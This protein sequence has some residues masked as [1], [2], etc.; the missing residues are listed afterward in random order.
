MNNIARWLPWALVVVAGCYVL[1]KARPPKDQ[2]AFLL[3]QAGQTPV[4]E[5]GR[6]KPLDTYARVALMVISDRQEL[7]RPDGAKLTA[8]EW[9][10][11]VMSGSPAADDHPIFR[12]EHEDVLQLAGLTPRSGL[13]YALADF[14]EAIPKIAEQ[15]QKALETPSAKRTI[16]QRKVLELGNHLRLYMTIARHDAPFLVPPDTGNDVHAWRQLSQ[17]DEQALD[18]ARG[19]VRMHAARDGV[20]LSHLSDDDYRDMLIPL[21]NAARARIS[22][23]AAMWSDML[24]AYGRGE[25]ATYNKLVGEYNAQIFQQAPELAGPTKFE[26]FFNSFAPFFWAQWL[27]VP[28]FVLVCL[29]WLAW[30]TPLLR[31]AMGLL[32]LILVVHTFGLIARMI[33]MDRPMVFVTNLYSSAVFIGWGAVLLTLLLE[34]IYRNGIGAALG[35]L[36]GFLTLHVAHHLALTSDGDTI[37]QMRA[38]LDTNFWLATHVTTVTMGYMATFVAG[39]ISI[40][41]IL[42]GLFTPALTKPAML[43]VSQKIYGVLCFALLLSFTGTVLGGIWA[44]QS[45]GR[46]WGWDPKENGALLIVIWNAVIL[47]ARWGGM[48]KARGTA[49]MAVFGNIVTCWSWFGVNELGVGLHS[50]GFTEGT[51]F[52]LA[53]FCLS[54]LAIIGLGLIPM[55]WWFSTRAP[56]ERASKRPPESLLPAGA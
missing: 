28:V 42:G 54:Q 4:L 1:S 50:Y 5:K 33:I 15:D 38:V 46:F 35:A 20:D 31:A 29:A 55:K 39:F 32:A 44:D 6:I 11:D 51:R 10:M 3:T 19:A 21:V 13:R 53:M 49:V 12:I 24:S 14:H 26:L 22:P 40:A 23:K 52:W 27:Y 56:I 41:F 37:E 2:G 16:F 34:L 45:W 48:I 8:I 7:T 18:L 17:I 9:L 36:I 47:H 30:R 25:A 43:K